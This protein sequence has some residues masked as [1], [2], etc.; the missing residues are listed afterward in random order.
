MYCARS[1]SHLNDML[2]EEFSA[3]S[4]HPQTRADRTE[5]GGVLSVL[6]HAQQRRLVL[7]QFVANIKAI[8]PYRRP[9]DWTWVH[10][11]ALSRAGRLRHPSRPV[12]TP[13][14]RCRHA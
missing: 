14:R 10:R 2:F 6:Y 5:N 9:Y 3:S 11:T 12:V 8:Y 4:K 13:S 7:R 1:L